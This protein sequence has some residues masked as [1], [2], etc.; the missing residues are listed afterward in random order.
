MKQ[1]DLKLNIKTMSLRTLFGSSRTDMSGEKYP[2]EGRATE[3]VLS[4]NLLSCPPYGVG[5]AVGGGGGR[6][7]RWDGPQLTPFSYDY[8]TCERTICIVHNLV[9][10]AALRNVRTYTGEQRPTHFRGLHTS[11]KNVMRSALPVSKNEESI[12]KQ[13]S[14]KYALHVS[15]VQTWENFL[16]FTVCQ[17]HPQNSHDRGPDFRKIL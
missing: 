8:I 17:I 4:P 10:M 1:L 13:T 5:A 3:N 12:S 16:V 11:A 9:G 14:R 15:H 2:T 6:S 7:W